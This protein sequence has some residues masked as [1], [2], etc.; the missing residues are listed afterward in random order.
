M[1][2][3]EISAFPLDKI[4]YFCVN[5]EKQGTVR[6]IERIYCTEFTSLPHH[7]LESLMA[8]WWIECLASN[9]WNII[10]KSKVPSPVGARETRGL[11]NLFKME[12]PVS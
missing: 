9:Q 5:K 4:L 3:Y 1:T 11:H 8:K 12:S 10:I 7:A 2:L 6:F